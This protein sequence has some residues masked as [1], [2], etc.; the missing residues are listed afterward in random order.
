M[1]PYQHFTKVVSIL[2]K[3][4][5]GYIQT[6]ED[7]NNHADFISFISKILKTGSSD[8]TITVLSE[9]NK[10]AILEKTMFGTYKFKVVK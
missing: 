8:K 7:R 2:H 3:L 5:K 1:V 6:A 9:S 10:K 4:K